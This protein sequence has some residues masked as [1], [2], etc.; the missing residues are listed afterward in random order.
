MAQSD[1]LK[2]YLDAG[3]AFTQMT[4]ER[5]EAIV[6][7][8]VKAGEVRRKEV[9]ENVEL[10]LERSRQNTE[11]LMAVVRREVVEQ[12]KNLGVIKDDATARKASAPATAGAPGEP[13]AASST[14]P[15]P[16]AAASTVKAA[17]KKAAATKTVKKATA[18]TATTTVKTVKKAAKASKK[19]QP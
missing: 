2:R 3:V 8:L 5:A 18:G 7:D 14:D 13:N 16:P 1:I 17:A 11:E 15:V 9:Q 6:Q 4:R 12:L 10:L 19:S